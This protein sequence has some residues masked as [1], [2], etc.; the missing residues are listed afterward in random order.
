MRDWWERAAKIARLPK[1]Q[2]LG[3]H[4][5]RR[6]FGTEYQHIAPKTLCHMGGWKSYSTILKCY[7]EPDEQ[8]MRDAYRWRMRRDEPTVATDSSRKTQYPAQ[9]TSL[10]GAVT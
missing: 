1:G 10:C 9:T 3:W 8:V 4:S 2:R 5:L 6:K 7:T